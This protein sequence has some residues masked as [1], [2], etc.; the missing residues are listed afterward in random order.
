MES[1]PK[2]SFDDTEIAFSYKTTGQLRKGNF[3]FSLV[4]HP[5]ISAMAT[6]SLKLALNLRLPI[7]GM[8]KKTAFEHFC[9]GETIEESK[10]VMQ[11]LGSFGVG[12]ILDYSV[13]GE[14]T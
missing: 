12:T 11:K 7:K 10:E 8:V 5:W 14:K 4:N 3:I 1:K 9:G 2:I 13:E 6:G